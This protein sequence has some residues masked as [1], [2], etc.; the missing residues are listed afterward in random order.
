MF[1]KLLKKSEKLKKQ[2]QK[3]TF[4][5]ILFVVA[6]IG[7]SYAATF[8]LQKFETSASIE[9]D[10]VTMYV[11]SINNERFLDEPA[12]DSEALEYYDD[13]HNCSEVV[14]KMPTKYDY[15]NT[16]VSI[17]FKDHSS[18]IPINKIRMGI[19]YNND[20]VQVG[21][22][23]EINKNPYEFSIN[24]YNEIKLYVGLW[25]DYEYKG[26]PG[27][28]NG[29]IV[30]Y[31]RNRSNLASTVIKDLVK[32]DASSGN[33][34]FLTKLPW[35]S[36]Y[37][38]DTE[39][40]IS[41]EDCFYC[42]YNSLHYRGE[43]VYKSN[44]SE[45]EDIGDEFFWGYDEEGARAYD[46]SSGNWYFKDIAF[47]ARTYTDYVYASYDGSLYYV[48]G[49]DTNDHLYLISRNYR[50][51][52][53]VNDTGTSSSGPPWRSN[54][55]AGVIVPETQ[56]EVKDY[57]GKKY[58]EFYLKSDMGLNSNNSSYVVGTTNAINRIYFY[59]K[60]NSVDSIH[61]NKTE[62]YLDLSKINGSYI[63]RINTDYSKG[64]HYDF[65]LIYSDIYE[66]FD[67]SWVYYFSHRA[68]ETGINAGNGFIPGSWSRNYDSGGSSGNSLSYAAYYTGSGLAI[69]MY[70]IGE[71]SEDKY[72]C[73]S[74]VDMFVSPRYRDLIYRTDVVIP[75]E[76]IVAY[77]QISRYFS[78]YDGDN[79]GSTSK[80]VNHI[81]F[82]LNNETYIT[83]GDG[84]L[85][86][87]FII[88][89]TSK[90]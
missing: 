45:Y 88:S 36:T 20:W 10:R 69:G 29:D 37:T 67:G 75:R 60:C 4:L 76:G 89:P 43:I 39:T 72:I 40:L 78:E 23:E 63:S 18:G 62:K 15:D 42:N 64:D 17:A 8:F 81:M 52:N 24:P 35:R 50:A 9:N 86:N 87:P 84:T 16:L 5:V 3:I 77:Q 47:D 21:T 65:R 12:K 30:V 13:D 70:G 7:I 51:T 58:P 74:N 66:P 19:R 71:Y 73:N 11:A 33:N 1:P 48:A 59:W 56:L 22:I 68:A 53:L 2:K 83:G 57:T 38:S 6:S 34:R 85:K 27:T 79:T 26:E 25:V 80:F 41:E 44:V 82:V 32:R 61:R 14:I 31:S 46:N 55:T 49:L 28:I 90:G 54:D